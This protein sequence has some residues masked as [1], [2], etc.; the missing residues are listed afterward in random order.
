MR[1]VA[2]DERSRSP[3]DGTGRELVVLRKKSV[4]RSDAGKG[5]A[6]SSQGRGVGRSYTRLG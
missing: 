6:V 2:R 3:F 4:R 5:R 1:N